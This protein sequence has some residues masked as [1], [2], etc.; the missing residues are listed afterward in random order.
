MK[1]KTE[2]KQLLI[3]LIVVTIAA[4]VIFWIAFNYFNE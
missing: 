1:I 3:D 2:T 4:C